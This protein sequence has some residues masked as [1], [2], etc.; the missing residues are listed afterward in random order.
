MQKLRVHLKDNLKSLS[1]NILIRLLYSLYLSLC[2]HR[3]CYSQLRI[4]NEDLH[5]AGV[6]RLLLLHMI[7]IRPF[8]VITDA[9]KS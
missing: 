4:K 1:L 5:P 9:K 2:E 8:L 7:C 3:K 6:F